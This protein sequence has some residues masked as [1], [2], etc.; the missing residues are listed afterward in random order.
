MKLVNVKNNSCFRECALHFDESVGLSCGSF[1]GA[2]CSLTMILGLCLRK[3]PCRWAILFEKTLF[4]WCA[5]ASVTP[6]PMTSR[7]PVCWFKLHSAAA[8]DKISRRCCEQGR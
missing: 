2:E 3:S 7:F 6:K 5:G 8:K 4:C 1:V